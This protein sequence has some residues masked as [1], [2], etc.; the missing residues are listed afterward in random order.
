[1]ADAEK[2]KLVEYQ[3]LPELDEPKERRKQRP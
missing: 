1:M 2:K 3:L